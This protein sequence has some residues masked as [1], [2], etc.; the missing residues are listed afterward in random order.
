MR[1]VV[2]FSVGQEIPKIVDNLG[3]KV[4]NPGKTSE[5]IPLTSGRLPVQTVWVNQQR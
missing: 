2:T 4:E 5:G 1:L 3:K